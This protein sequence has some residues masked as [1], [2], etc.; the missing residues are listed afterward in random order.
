MTVIDTQ[1]IM[2][3]GLHAC[4]RGDMLE[5]ANLLREFVRRVPASVDGWYNL[6]KALKSLGRIAEAVEAYHTAARLQPDDA[7]VLFNLGNALRAIGRSAEALDVYRKAAALNPSHPGL[8]TNLGLTLEE[9]GDRTTAMVCYRR[10][11][12]AD[13]SFGAGYTNLGLALL[14]EHRI[15]EA[16]DNCRRAVACD[17][18]M[19]EAH[20]N[21]AAVLL[22]QDRFAEADRAFAEA[23]RLRPEF[24]EALVNRAIGYMH[25]ERYAEAQDACERALNLRPDFAEAHV[26][27]AVTLLQT[28]A[29]HEGWRHYEWRFSTADG[30]NPRRYPALPEWDGRDIRGKRILLYQEQGLGDVLQCVRYAPLLARRGA[31]VMIACQRT[32]HALLTTSPGIDAVVAPG[33]MPA[34]TDYVCPIFSLPRLFGTTP[35]S[36][37]SEVPYLRPDEKTIER[38][39]ARISHVD[40]TLNVGIA[41]TGNPVHINN[42]RRSLPE[43]ALQDL[44][45]TEGVTFHSLHAG[46]PDDAVRGRL[47]RHDDHLGDF[48]EVAGLMR[49]VDLVVTVDTSFA[50]LAGGL[51]VPVWLLLN[52]GCD[53]RWMTGRSDSP[54]YPTMTVYRQHQPLSWDDA[55]ARVRLELLK[56]RGASTT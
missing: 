42:R 11:V 37:P 10:A 7:D 24:P 33:E 5:G 26:N 43:A 29:Y 34:A 40:G 52:R 54:W 14:R 36:I 30:K 15:Q 32:L 39:R 50:H 48:A 22:E 49:A 17:P 45:A 55:I 31:S 3:S 23:L 25:S 1:G 19:P 9:A 56:C 12:E 18:G 8:L 20:Y 46:P 47:V 35:E 13:P 28:G 2:Q 41:W 4:M 51:G 53:W 38:W 6:G 21:L 27:L 16:E 44:L